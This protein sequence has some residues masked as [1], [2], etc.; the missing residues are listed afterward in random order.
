LAKAA[1]ALA[2]AKQIWLMDTSVIRS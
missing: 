2:F 1:I